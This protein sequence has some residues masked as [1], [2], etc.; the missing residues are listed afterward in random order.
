MADQDEVTGSWLYSGSALAIVKHL[1]SKPVDRIFP[2]L[3]FTLPFKQW[4]NHFFFNW[5]ILSRCVFFTWLSGQYPFLFLLLE[6]RQLHRNGP[7][8]KINKNLFPRRYL[9]M[10]NSPVIW[11]FTYSKNK[12]IC[13][14]YR[15]ENK[16]ESR[17][18]HKMK[19][20]VKRKRSLMI[21]RLPIGSYIAMNYIPAKGD[22]YL[23]C[24]YSLGMQ[25]GGQKLISYCLSTCRPYVH[26][27]ARQRPR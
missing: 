20:S 17:K 25:L 11:E 26:Y 2:L 16:T 7:V 1:G 24:R 22:N 5:A 23:N 3:L 15:S 6:E 10:P 21:R 8:W 13:I 27:A 19:L 9:C 12:I 4:R 18:Q 14:D